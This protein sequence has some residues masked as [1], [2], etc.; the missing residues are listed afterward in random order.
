MEACGLRGFHSV[1]KQALYFFFIFSLGQLCPVSALLGVVLCG[2]KEAINLNAIIAYGKIK[3]D[4]ISIS[5]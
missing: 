1:C 4:G 5:Q 2:H 3:P